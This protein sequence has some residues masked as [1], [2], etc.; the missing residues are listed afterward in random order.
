MEALEAAGH[1]PAPAT[2]AILRRYLGG[3][4][5]PQGP[6]QGGALHHNTKEGIW[7]LV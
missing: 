1:R 4:E 6:A 5:M 3:T 7:Q 2:E